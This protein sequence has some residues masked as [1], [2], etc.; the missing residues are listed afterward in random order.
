[1]RH[2]CCVALFLLVSVAAPSFGQAVYGSI[3][4][5]VTDSSG[6]A[7]PSAKVTIR[8]VGKG[9]SYS[10]ATN[11]TGNYSQIHL[12]VG[13]YEVRVEAKG[14]D[15]FVQQNVSVEVDASTQINA[16]LHPGAIGETVNVSAEAALL[17]TEKSDISDTMTEK[18]VM[19][20]PVFSRDMSRLYF[21]IPGVQATGTTAASEQPQDIYRPTIGGQYWGGIAFLLD[22]TDNRESVLGEPVITP[23]LDSVSELKITTT[24]YDAE[25]GQAS[26]A[27]I[28]AQ[29]KSGT[30][31]FHGGAFEYR[32]DQ[33]GAARD[34]F[35]QSQPIV[36]TNGQ[37]IPPSLWNQFGGSIGG[38]IQKDKTFFFGDYQ[39]TRQK[40]GGSLL[41]R[42][43]NAAERAGDLSDLGVPIWNP[44]NGSDCN[45]ALASRSQFNNAVIPTS[46]LSPQAGNLL[47]FIPLPNIAGVT[48]ASPNYAASGSGIVNWDGFDVRID[49]YQTE[50]LHM[51]GRY[52][53]LQ[54]GQTVPGAFGF[55]AGGPNF[56]TTAFGGAAS[57][58][59]QSVSY[60]ADYVI[61]PTWLT[62]FRFGFF[63]YRVFVN[64]NGLGTSPAKDA[65]IPGLNLDDYYTS[66]MPRFN[67]NGIGGFQFGYALGTN[68]CNCPLNEQENEYQWV[69]N[70]THNFGNHSLKFGLDFRFQQNLRVPSDSH[71]AG[72]LTFD[73]TTTEGPNGGGLSLASYLLGDVQSFIRYIS[74]S[75]DAAE[76][77]KRTF[78]YIQDTWR[79][80]PKLTV[81]IGLRWEIY[82]PQYVNGKDRGGYQN[83]STGEVLITGENGIG[84]NGNVNTAFTHFAPRI[85]IAYQVNPKTVVRTGYGRSYDVG[86]F[87]VSFGHNVTQNVPVLANQSL[88]PANPWL[89][90]FTLANGPPSLDPS[91]ILATQPK[92]PTGNPILPNGIAPNVLP[93]SSNNTMRLPV[94]DAWNFTVEHQL[95]PSFVLSLAYVGNHG[96]HVTAGGTNYNVNQPSINGFGVLSTNQRRLFYQEFGWTQSIKYFSDDASVKFNSLQARAEKRFSNG[97]MFQGNFTWASAFD[98]ANDYFFWNHDIDYGRENG[99]RRFVFNL[100]NVYALPFGRQQKFLNNA[101]RALDL[102]VGGW[103]LSGTWTWQSGVPFTP[104]YADCGRDEDTGPCRAILVGSASVSDPN[105]HEWYAVATPGTSGS[106]CLATGTATPELNAN[107]CTR[108]PWM[109]PQAGTFGTVAR[110]SFFGPHYFNADA[111]LA[112]AF[113]ITEKINAQFRAELFN[114]F[115]HVNLGQP[116]AT[117]DSPTAG[118]ITGLAG[119]SQMRKWQFGIRL[120]F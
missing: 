43:P 96:Y 50:K 64:P 41:T 71:R 17:K 38:P 57:L 2:S 26:Q 39:G 27:I 51:F 66:G 42:V 36:G 16:Q 32:R 120:N 86:V 111:S 103:Q 106:G 33:H 53:F 13:Q 28:S 95:T 4:G 35:A 65:G 78:S 94:V 80:T 81:N 68:S 10:T 20:L 15:S 22:G 19:E 92:G 30:N 23:N 83:L 113:N 105:R 12:I 24:A 117:V 98:F 61:S 52:S 60:G 9:V 114:A 108:G 18:A 115:N 104:G 45:V 31:Q 97:L 74:N 5:T 90:V 6:A 14:F 99:V 69:G 63:R 37:F 112:K 47:K 119:L 85:G 1:M 72:E 56:A 88:N 107:G 25:F 91:T 58:R 82:F 73:P 59:D 101:P 7:I 100:N 29:T 62:D 110:N 76:R 102:F 40:N 49:R 89:P 46:L 21:L 84:L 34:P 93:L 116:N 3:V 11:E 77:Q 67:L 44:C 8:D 70:V 118:Q 54:V 48:G 75:T 109:R 87:G 79:I 55:E